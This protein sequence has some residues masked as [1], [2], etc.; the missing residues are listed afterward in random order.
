MFP[1][2]LLAFCC[3]MTR[4]D[5]SWRRPLDASKIPRDRHLDM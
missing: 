4:I 3:V 5:T 2:G 1:S